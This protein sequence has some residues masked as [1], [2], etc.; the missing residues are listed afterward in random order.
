MPKTKTVHTLE[1]IIVYFRLFSS[2]AAVETGTMIDEGSDVLE[3]YRNVAGVVL[4]IS[5]DLHQLCHARVEFEQFSK[6]Q[7]SHFLVQMLQYLQ[8]VG[9]LPPTPATNTCM[10]S[11]QALEVEVTDANTLS[12]SFALAFRKTIG[13]ELVGQVIRILSSSEVPSRA[14]RH[15]PAF[16][17]YSLARTV[18]V[19]LF[20]IS[21]C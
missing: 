14:D 7:D 3:A 1:S 8:Q 5:E 21:L 16:L 12:T 2:D 17:C 20:Q 6:Y 13:S 19:H 15:L 10:L 18:T 11:S 9:F 4:G